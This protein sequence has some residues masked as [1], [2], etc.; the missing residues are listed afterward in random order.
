MTDPS[1]LRAKLPYDNWPY[2]SDAVAVV[3][4]T[5]SAAHVGTHA[6]LGG[7]SPRYSER[8]SRRDAINLLVVNLDQA[9][10]GHFFLTAFLLICSVAL[11]GLILTV[12]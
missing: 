11:A 4:D 12:N 3:P 8:S 10:S 9:Y 7:G 5:Q 6:L 2:F 1:S